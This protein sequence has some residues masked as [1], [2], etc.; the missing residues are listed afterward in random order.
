MM[1]SQEEGKPG[2]LSWSILWMFCL[3]ILGSTMNQELKQLPC[4]TELCATIENKCVIFQFLPTEEE[5]SHVY[6]LTLNG[7]TLYHILSFDPHWRSDLEIMPE[8]FVP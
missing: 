4:V 3:Y 6:C 2:R 8:A 5:N 1:D 7:C